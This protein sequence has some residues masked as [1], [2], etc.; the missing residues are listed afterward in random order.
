VLRRIEVG[1]SAIQSVV[2][3]VRGSWAGGRPQQPG[4]V[5]AH[6]L[7]AT[8]QARRRPRWQRWHLEAWE[9]V[10][11]RG[12]IH[13]SFARAITCSNAVPNLPVYE[14][15]LPKQA[16]ERPVARGSGKFQP[17]PRHLCP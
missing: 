2:V 10:E 6:I 9:T 15:G 3:V 4:A 16:Y 1:R 5:S 7:R 11:L 12:R 17:S 14:G 8:N 13:G